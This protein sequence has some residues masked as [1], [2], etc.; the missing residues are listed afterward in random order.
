MN[1]TG[2]LDI[3]KERGSFLEHYLYKSTHRHRHRA[4][5]E[6]LA[7]DVDVHLDLVERDKGVY[8]AYHIFFFSPSS[9]HLLFLCGFHRI[10]L[11]CELSTSSFLQPF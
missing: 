5:E 8:G 10:S 6:Q 4:R 1:R 7:R 3:S 2:H 11:S 9:L